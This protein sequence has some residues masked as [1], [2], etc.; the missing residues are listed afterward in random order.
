MSDFFGLSVPVNALGRSHVVEPEP[1]PPAPG[2]RDRE[3][4]AW[5][6]WELGPQSCLGRKANE[7]RL[8]STVY[9]TGAL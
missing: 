2:V 3:I 7:V 8:T 4:L 1:D 6:E 5:R 9:N